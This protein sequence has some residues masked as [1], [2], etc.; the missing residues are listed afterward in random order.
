MNVQKLNSA[1]RS[2][3]RSR[4]RSNMI[5]GITHTP[6]RERPLGRDDEDVDASTGSA[7]TQKSASQSLEKSD[8]LPHL[9]LDTKTDMVRKVCCIC[10][11]M[12]FNCS[13]IYGST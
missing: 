2:L 11:H 8:V 9:Y 7:H 1:R 12:R 10:S 6:R 13:N 5:S 3:R 4:R